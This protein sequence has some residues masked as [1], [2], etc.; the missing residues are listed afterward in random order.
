MRLKT[1]GRWKGL[2]E[3]IQQVW[4]ELPTSCRRAFFST[5]G[6]LLLVAGVE[7]VSV[8]ALFPLFYVVLHSEQASSMPGM[9]W[10]YAWLNPT[11]EA[12]FV[13]QLMGGVVLVFLIKE[14]I[15]VWAR[16]RHFRHIFQIG[17]T[18]ARSLLRDYYRIPY[19][20]VVRENP[21]RFTTMIMNLAYSYAQGILLPLL[22]LFT[23]A[24]ILVLLAGIAML[25]NPELFMVLLF[26]VG[27]ALWGGMFLLRR[28]AHYLSRRT[29]RLQ[30][31]SYQRLHDATRHVFEIKTFGA[32]SFFQERFL[33]RHRQLSSVFADASTLAT[34]PRHFMEVVMLMGVGVLII[35]ALVAQDI[36]PTITFM[37]LFLAVSYRL[38]PSINR[39][40]N[41]VTLL[42]KNQ[43]ILHEMAWFRRSVADEMRTSPSIGP[44]ER[45]ITFRNVAFS[46]QDSTA[47]LFSNVDMEWP[48]GKIT[49][50][51]GPSGAGKT[52]LF[53]LAGGF[54]FPRR[55][56][57][58]VDDRPIT[59]YNAPSWYS[60]V[61]YM[62][63]RPLFF[64][65]SL[66]A[67]LV[68][69]EKN[70]DPAKV[71]RALEAVNL[72]ELV[73]QVPRHLHYYIGEGGER[74][75]DGQ[76]QRLAL[77]RLLYFDPDV[78]FLD[79]P[80]AFLDHHLEERIFEVFRRLRS[81]GKTLVIISHQ[82]SMVALADVVYRVQKGGVIYL[83]SGQEVL[84]A[85][86]DNL[87]DILNWG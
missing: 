78:W 87:R 61:G 30:P 72:M 13:L 66:L 79:E 39:I 52:T 41:S 35:K 1:N 69:H 11:N 62:P 5:G 55:G 36:I 50:L 63:A 47:P 33:Q 23:E 71:Y 60:R 42:Q 16:H 75:S 4:D 32:T 17:N 25:I 31:T 22:N 38:A 6:G 82:A 68:L 29:Q 14:L 12:V 70:Y 67:N 20:R 9:R 85:P 15:V 83:G 3:V 27:P 26:V 73:D 51:I 53:R 45:C 24:V 28:W 19:E 80:T 77:A 74:L 57:V 10:L 21:Y 65:G 43:Y 58:L 56:A 59:P 7:V 37:G 64:A 18:L 44:F 86:D 46:Y 8:A 49:V 81:R 40:M 54:V 76:R 2:W 34:L 48:R 84:T